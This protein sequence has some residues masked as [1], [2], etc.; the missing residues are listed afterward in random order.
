M[1]CG[2]ARRRKRRRE[3]EE[4][5][6]DEPNAFPFHL[7]HFRKPLRLKLYLFITGK[8]GRVFLNQSGGIVNKLLTQTAEDEEKTAGADGRSRRQE[9]TAGADGRSRYQHFS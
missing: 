2:K 8:G 7:V 5:N 4:R 6:Q 3:R 9:Q 1:E